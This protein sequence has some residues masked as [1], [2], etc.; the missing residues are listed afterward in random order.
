MA[1]AMIVRLRREYGQFITSGAQLLLLA[2]GAKLESRD[3][4][5]A[6]LGLMAAISLIAWRSTL[7]RRRAIADTPTSRIA[8]A[9]QGYVELRGNGRPLDEAPVYSH[10]H[11]LPCLWYRY[12][13]EEKSGSGDK[14]RTVGHGESDAA[15]II[16]DGSARCVVD[17][18]GAEILSRHKE[19][20]T[21]GNTRTTEWTLLA[22]DAIYALGEFRSIGGSTLPLDAQSDVKALLAEMKK[23]PTQLL[24]RFDL[25]GDGRID[26]TEWALARQAARREIEKQ[27]RAARNESDVHTLSCP[28]SGQLYLISNLDPDKIARRYL[29]WSA[30]HLATFFAALGALPWVWHNAF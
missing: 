10:L 16:D 25:D 14:W 28:T 30:F 23:N 29:Y 9:A 22:D 18:E 13:V 8:S 3:A 15:F 5:L 19:T 20:R 4:W 1:H 6:C 17:V 24:E 2:V 12:Q 11:A 7:H 21:Q 27:H 26:M